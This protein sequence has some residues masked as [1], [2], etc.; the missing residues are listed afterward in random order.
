MWGR[1]EDKKEETERAYD[2]HDLVLGVMSAI[3]DSKS[4]IDFL[5]VKR[6]EQAEKVHSLMKELPLTTFT[7]NEVEIELKYH[8]VP[9]GKDEEELHADKMTPKV[10]V[11]PYSEKIDKSE[12]SVQSIKLKLTPT[13]IKKYLIDKQEK[14]KVEDL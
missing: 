10:K 8:I 4:D 12:A 7:L 13:Q 2:L 3:T 5:S 11:L 9:L 6:R 1:K 14:F